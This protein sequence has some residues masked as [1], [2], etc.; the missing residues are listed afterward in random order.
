MKTIYRWF[1]TILWA[2][3][4]WYLTT[5]PDFKVTD[6]SLL[7]AILSNGGHIFF[8]GILAIFL[9]LSRPTSVVSTSLYGLLIELYQRGVP[10]RSGDPLDWVLDTFGAIIFLA[11]TKKIINQKFSNSPI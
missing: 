9:P 1:L 7:S 2:Y 10:G 5:I 6:N 3:L 4:I 8:F 11:I